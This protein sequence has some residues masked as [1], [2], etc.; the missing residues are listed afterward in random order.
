MDLIFD[1]GS[2]TFEKK[3]KIK[4]PRSKIVFLTFRE[5]ESRTSTFL[6]VFLTLFLTRIACDEARFFER[7]TQV[8]I[9]FHQRTR[10]AVTDRTG[11]S[12]CAAAVDI[13]EKVKF[14]NSLRKAKR[15]TNDHLQRFVREVG[16]EITLVNRDLAAARA[17]VN[18]CCRSFSAACAV[19][20]NVCHKVS[21]EF[22]VRSFES[23]ILTLNSK[24]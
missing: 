16:V 5:L 24:R 19:I 20:L 7:R 22:G 23:G 17:K 4:S 3:S 13:D 8:R 14:L 1:L 9:K 15:L 6:P 21:S 2:S 12:G 10:D 18:T 11:L